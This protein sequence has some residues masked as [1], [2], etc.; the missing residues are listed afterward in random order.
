MKTI[1]SLALLCAGAATP[2]LAVPRPT[3]ASAD[4]ALK[5][6][7]LI[8]RHPFSS[9]AQ[10]PAAWN[11]TSIYTA[12][13]VV[14]ENAVDYKANWWTQDQD[15]A[16]NSGPSGSGQPWTQSGSCSDCSAPPAS[17]TSLAASGTTSSATTLAWKQ[18]QLAKCTITGYGIY[19]NGT[20]VATATASPFTVTGLAAKTKYSFTVTAIDSVGASAPS[21]ARTVTTKAGS[22][23]GG[24]TTT[25]TIDFHLLLGAGS[26]E[27]SLTLDGGNYTDLIMSNIIAGVM[28]AHLVEE[29][30]PGIQFN[31][32][33]L[34]GSL[35][36]QLLQENIATEYYVDTSTLIDPS[37]D[38]QA[39]M[40]KGQG[41]PYQI[42][43]YAVDLVSGTYAPEGH[44]L[45]NYIAIQSNI[46][47]TM[48]NAAT[49][50]TQVTPPSFNNKY[51]GPLLPAFF[52]YNDMVALN[53]IGT[54]PDGYQ[55]PWQPEYDEAL[56]NFVTLPDSFLDI[57]LN[58][59]YNQG[60]YGTLVP[61]YSK[62]GATATPATVTAVTA[63][64][65][66]WGNADTY[67]QYPFQVHYYLD[68][69]YDNPL[70]TSATT[71][72]TP[73]NH[74]I[75]TMSALQAVFLQVAQ[76]L[77]YSNGTAA[78]QYFTAAQATTAFTTA[79]SQTGTAATAAL[80]LSAAAD[81]AQIF[82]V[83]NHALTNLE[84]AGGM[85]FNATTLSQL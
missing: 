21:A 77:D 30:F 73:A 25:G 33:Y 28:Y 40:G 24:G 50:Y 55:T 36:G 43:N 31:Q 82:A 11:A 18:V 3:P 27:D 60:Y 5:I 16:T 69:F 42:N 83:I 8:P 71:F 64:S 80:D 66:V 47:Y 74:V 85:Q 4:R 46:G 76:T 57:I 6:L 34:V 70:P 79:L 56:A 2:A 52:H 78:A 32:D 39:V 65:T 26:A 48:A 12:G 7:G 62:L 15:P 19:E 41:G 45:I 10:C 51:Y 9:A 81:R 54:G 53:V 59:A 38:Q 67:A 20:L 44:A 58:V 68:Q 23:G 72:T 37:P 63:Y 22:S 17:P 49:Q 84:T 75:F 35:L 1:L 61:Y 29:G 14:S 13:D